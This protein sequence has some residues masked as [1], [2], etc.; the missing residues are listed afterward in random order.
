[1]NN[2]IKQLESA[3]ELSTTLIDMH[4]QEIE[5]S[6]RQI[7]DAKDRIQKETQAISDYKSAIAAI[8]Q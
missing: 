1:M 7:A 6:E 3:I 5:Q 2:A 4:N 8:N